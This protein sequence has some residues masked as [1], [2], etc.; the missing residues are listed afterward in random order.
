LFID[1]CFWHGCPA[2]GSRIT[3]A[4][5]AY[6]TQKIKMNQAR[7][8][9]TDALLALS[10]WLVIRA[11]EHEDPAVVAAAVLRAVK[12]RRKTPAKPMEYR[13]ID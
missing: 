3:K 4:N 7:D 1:G 12:D 11:W 13:Q 9:E 8:A 5:P 10:G 2:H 6:W